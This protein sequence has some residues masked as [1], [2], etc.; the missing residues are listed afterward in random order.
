MTSQ[1]DPFF[2]LGIAAALALLAALPARAQ[3]FAVGN[4][5][6]NA[7]EQ[8]AF[9]LINRFRADPQGELSRLL[10]TTQSALYG[11]VTLSSTG[12][13]GDG[14]AW[15]AGF[16]TSRSAAGN[17]AADALDY[18]HVNPGDLLK[19]WSLLP[20]AGTLH[21]YTWNTNLGSSAQQYANLIV[22]DAGATGNV[23]AISPYA[24]FGIARFSDAGYGNAT[25]VGE[26]VARDFF[27]SYPAY[28]HAGFAID[29]GGAGNG[30][31][32]PAG[33]RNS[34]LS[35][36]FTEVG[37]G[38]ANGY[39]NTPDQHVTQVQHFGDRD[40]AFAEFLWGYA[41]Q[42]GSGGGYTFGEGLQGL[43]IN[44]LDASNQIV[45][46]T[47]TDAHGGYTLPVVGL[48]DGSYAV[49]FRDGSTV[50]G[51]RPVTIGSAG[52]YHVDFLSAP[53]PVPEPATWLMLAGGLVPLAL[54]RR[55]LSARS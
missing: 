34:M 3:T 5:L 9:D 14:T 21:P 27:P 11:G 18:F 29:W 13:A 19:Q 43:T 4:E 50:L 15:S 8:T 36:T 38:L 45:G 37:I 2:R 33:H 54:R 40:N 47:T 41:W 24:P 32:N 28:L 26:N 55:A 51:T 22:A 16:W 25:T 7:S 30:I 1:Q 49:Q 42:D 20:A 31:Q 6:P 53:A 35:T 17:D 52:L 12:T 23:H 48:P 44:L 46:T 39:T 10:G